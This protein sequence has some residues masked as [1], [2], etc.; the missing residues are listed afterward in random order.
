MT[1][2][3]SPGDDVK[4]NEK[5][6]GCLSKHYPLTVGRI[7]QCLGFMGSNIITTTDEPGESASYYRGRV[8][9]AP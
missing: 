3:I 7:Y 2:A 5:P 6:D 4:L 9:K 8:S 1:P